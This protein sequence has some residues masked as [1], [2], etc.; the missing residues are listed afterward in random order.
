MTQT[1]TDNADFLAKLEAIK[2]DYISTA[3]PVQ[4][5]DVRDKFSTLQ[6]LSGGAEAVSYALAVNECAHKLTGSS[7]TFGLDE[8][9]TLSR[10]V[11]ELTDCARTKQIAVSIDTVEEISN[12]IN[13]LCA[14]AEE[15]N[16]RTAKSASN[17][18]AS[19]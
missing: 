18:P 4:I 15:E 5:A 3:L 13:Q 2:A 12:L 14:L 7:G 16:F 17:K 8:I 9:S 6:K 11:Y 1:K 10:K 19:E